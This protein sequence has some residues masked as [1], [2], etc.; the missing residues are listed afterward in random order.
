MP[1]HPARLTISGLAWT[2][3][4]AAEKPLPPARGRAKAVLAAPRAVPAWCWARVLLPRRPDGPFLEAAEPHG[5]RLGA[6]APPASMGTNAPPR[7]EPLA[8]GPHVSQRFRF[9]PGGGPKV[10]R[11]GGA[12][13]E[14]SAGVLALRRLREPPFVSAV[15]RRVSKWG[16]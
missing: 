2:H 8:D 3:P 1:W 10:G 14:C 5:K 9:L 15:P 13:G 11:F 6:G 16:Q 12:G 4:R 7:R